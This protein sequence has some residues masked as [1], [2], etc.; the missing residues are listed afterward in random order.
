[1]RIIRVAMSKQAMPANTYSDL[2]LG[3]WVKETENY[4]SIV[5][6]L[7]SDLGEKDLGF[8][9]AR[10]TDKDSKVWYAAG[11]A[12]HGWGPFL[13]DLLMKYVTKRG[14]YLVSHERARKMG[15]LRQKFPEDI[16]LTSPSA[17]AMWD[18]YY[19]RDDVEDTEYGFRTKELQEASNK[20]KLIRVT[21][22]VVSFK[23]TIPNETY[24]CGYCDGLLDVVD[25]TV[26]PR[27]HFNPGQEYMCP[28]GKSQLWTNSVRYID[29]L[30]DYCD[31]KPVDHTKDP[32]KWGFCNDEFCPGCWEYIRVLSNGRLTLDGEEILSNDLWELC[33]KDS[34]KM[35]D[36]WI[37]GRVKQISPEDIYGCNGCV[38]NDRIIRVGK[39]G[40]EFEGQEITAHWY[41][42]HQDLWR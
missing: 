37:S 10:E 23:H 27:H 4:N 13:Y 17:Q 20:A 41:R 33:D 36:M 12:E 3:Y 26:N 8:A 14:C 6:T 22:R 15:L 42:D 24:K 28:C 29:A 35:R 31:G 9:M 2:P 1:M 32:E 19:D 5:Y 40:G 7:K 18:K 21:K 16:S 39:K 30:K 38:N 11:Q 25:V 34:D